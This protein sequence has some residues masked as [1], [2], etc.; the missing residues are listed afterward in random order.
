MGNVLHEIL[1]FH[2][3][4]HPIENEHTLLNFARHLGMWT[5]LIDAYDDFEDDQKH[6]RFNP[7]THLGMNFCQGNSSYMSLQCGEI[8]LG[9]MSINLSALQENITFYRHNE[10]IENI[11]NYGTRNAVQTIKK[12]KEKEKDACNRRK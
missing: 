7:L 6:H 2:F 5:Y 10:I 8:M 1:A 4:N 11:V 3:R 12:K 9:M